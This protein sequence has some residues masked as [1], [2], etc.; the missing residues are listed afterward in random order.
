MENSL[1]VLLIIGA[2]SVVTNLGAAHH[3]SGAAMLVAPLHIAVLWFGFQ[4]ASW[5]G[6]VGSLLAVV[7]VSALIAKTVFKNSIQRVRSY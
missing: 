3:K 4:W 7:F 5:L 6:A 1:T 2:I